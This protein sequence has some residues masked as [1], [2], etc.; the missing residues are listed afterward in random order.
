MRNTTCLPRGKPLLNYRLTRGECPRDNRQGQGNN[1]WAKQ[2]LQMW[3]DILGREVTVDENF[4]GCGIRTNQLSFPP[5][6]RNPPIL[7]RP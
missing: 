3:Q 5:T 4:L 7:D 2:A 1:P 6:G